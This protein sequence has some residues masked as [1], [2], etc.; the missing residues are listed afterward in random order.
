MR[1][2]TIV[3]LLS[4]GMHFAHTFV[5][6]EALQVERSR[7]VIT[8]MAGRKWAK[9]HQILGVGGISHGYDI[10]G[11]ESKQRSASN[12][13]ILSATMPSLSPATDEYTETW[14]RRRH[15][16]APA[17]SVAE[18]TVLVAIVVVISL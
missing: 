2:F 11:V 4:V 7:P 5:D 17:S 12:N 1:S 3:L 13:C 10:C 18:L 8:N 14:Y 9:T 6:V 15:D 16:V